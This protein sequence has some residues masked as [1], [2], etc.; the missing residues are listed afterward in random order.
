MKIHAYHDNCGIAHKN[1][2]S[3]MFINTLE[4]NS[5]TED[6]VVIFQEMDEAVGHCVNRN[7]LC[8]T[9]TRTD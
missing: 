1:Q 5:H 3:H 9:Y 4:S 8:T 7:E 2:G 6:E